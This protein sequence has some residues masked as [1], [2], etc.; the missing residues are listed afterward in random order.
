[1]KII[2]KI[3]LVIYI[4]VLATTATQGQDNTVSNLIQNLIDVGFKMGVSFK[5]GDRVSVPT[6]FLIPID[7][8]QEKGFN[9]Y[10]VMVNDNSG[11]LKPFYIQ[12]SRKLATGY[13]REIFEPLLIEYVGIAQ[14]LQNGNSRDTFLFKEVSSVTVF[15]Q[16]DN[17]G[18]CTK[19]NC[20]NGTG[21]LTRPNGEQYVGQFKNGK[22]EG[23]GA[24]TWA[25]G[26]KYVGRWIGGLMD[27]QGTRTGPDGLK[28]VGQWRDG[29]MNGQ[30]TLTWPGG[31][32]Y[33]GQWKD[34]KKDGQ[35]TL[36]DQNGVYVGQFKDGEED[37]KGTLTRTDGHKYVGQ[38]V[39]GE[40]ISG[41]CYDKEGRQVDCDFK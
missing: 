11:Q 8:S 34:G 28:Y 15:K 37:G 24:L 40:F 27:G 33:I 25:G 35:G 14:Y 12:T 18:T 26:Q 20:T 41:N 23:Q 39:N 5:A 21:S 9:I 17:E 7:L 38:W 22:Y 16:G 1:M 30:G 4:T 2:K 36:T 32:K 13:N 6:G 31:Q 3:T 19:G 29:L 10:L